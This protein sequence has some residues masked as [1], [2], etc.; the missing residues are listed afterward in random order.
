M[1]VFFSKHRFVRALQLHRP[2][3]MLPYFDSRLDARLPEPS[4]SILW[5]DEL[6]GTNNGVVTSGLGA[7]WKVY[8]ATCNIGNDDKLQ[9]GVEPETGSLLY[10]DDIRRKFIETPKSFKNFTTPYDMSDFEMCH[11]LVHVFLG[12]HM[13]KLSC[14][15]NDPI[16]WLHHS[17]IDYLFDD[18]LQTPGFD[19]TYP[20][21]PDI[22][23]HSVPTS[24]RS[25]APLFPFDGYSLADVSQKQFMSVDYTYDRSPGDIKCTT[26]S[27][28]KSEFLWCNSPNCVSK[29]RSRGFCG[30]LPDRCCYCT[31]GQK[32]LKSA[33]GYC[34]CK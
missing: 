25:G 23:G 20:S 2:G 28:C 9:R 1:A 5:S 16:F 30:K 21:D 13:T 18:L 32:A 7:G 3:L 26:D 22:F 12:G 24:H 31:T 6:F 27:Q 19:K 34:S 17:F 4:H 8:P 29:V 15:P 33:A 11:S 14:A 10:G